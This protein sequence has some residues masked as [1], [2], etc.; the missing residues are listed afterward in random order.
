MSG[1]ID[2]YLMGEYKAS[3]CQDTLRQ[4]H[5]AELQ[6][7]PQVYKMN[8]MYSTYRSWK[9]C[10]PKV[11]FETVGGSRKRE[12]DNIIDI[13]NSLSTLYKISKK[14]IGWRNFNSDVNYDGRDETTYR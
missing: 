3:D 10:S 6:K 9:S 11:I 5:R 8:W 1:S 13:P 2:G 7:T 4:V 12:R 14:R